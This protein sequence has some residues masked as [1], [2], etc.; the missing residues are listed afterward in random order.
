MTDT[1]DTFRAL[2]DHRKALRAKYGV[3]CPECQRLLPKAQPKILLP[4]EYCRMHK[5][6]DPRPELTNDG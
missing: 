2:K 6:T 4:Q 1:I 5:F 3:P